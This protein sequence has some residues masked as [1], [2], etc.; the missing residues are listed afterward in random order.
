MAD[1]DLKKKHGGEFE[2]VANVNETHNIS[3]IDD[4]LQALV[5]SSLPFYRKRNLTILYLLMF[6]VA[7]FLQ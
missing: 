2:T 3:D 6:P 5:K 4:R 1:A 7:F